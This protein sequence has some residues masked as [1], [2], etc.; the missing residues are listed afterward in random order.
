MLGL[1]DLFLPS[2]QPPV[3]LAAAS[4]PPTPSHRK[5]RLP[6]HLALRCRRLLPP[7]QPP[8]RWPPGWPVTRKCEKPT[9]IGVSQLLL[10]HVLCKPRPPPQCRRRAARLVRQVACWQIWQAACAEQ[11]QTRAQALASSVHA[12][13][14]KGAAVRRTCWYAASV[15]KREKKN[16][17]RTEIDIGKS[18]DLKLNKY[19]SGFTMS[20]SLAK[21]IQRRGY[22]F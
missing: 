12:G 9:G 16:W 18:I 3:R 15:I 11:R 22:Y 6:R 8:P 7:P 19:G 13:A 20:G 5:S 21:R 10:G 14:D 4:A 2:S 17:N 1:C